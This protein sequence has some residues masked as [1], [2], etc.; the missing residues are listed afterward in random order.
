MLI[1]LTSLVT[2]DKIQKKSSFRTRLVD[3]ISTETKIDFFWLPFMHSV[4]ITHRNIKLLV[5]DKK[6]TLSFNR[7]AEISTLFYLALDVHHM[8]KEMKIVSEHIFLCFS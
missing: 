4:S 6:G 5:C 8:K 7:P 3:L 2:T 1:S